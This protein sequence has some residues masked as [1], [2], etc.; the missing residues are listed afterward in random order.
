MPKSYTLEIIGYTI[1]NGKEKKSWSKTI[2]QVTVYFNHKFVPTAVIADSF[3]F[4]VWHHCG[5]FMQFQ[6]RQLYGSLSL[7]GLNQ[8]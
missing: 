7:H 4:M 3:H 2:V 1:N 6:G 5:L 8:C